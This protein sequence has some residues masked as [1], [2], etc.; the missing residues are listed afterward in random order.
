MGPSSLHRGIYHG[1]P[2]LR[3]LDARRGK[4]SRQLSGTRKSE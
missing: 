3:G 2:M 4:A 1:S